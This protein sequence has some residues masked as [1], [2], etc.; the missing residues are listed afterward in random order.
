VAYASDDAEAKK[1]FDAVAAHLTTSGSAVLLKSESNSSG[2]VNLTVTVPRNAKVTV[3]ANKGDVSASG[4]GA[5]ITATVGGDVQL[6]TIA[7]PV[8]AHFPHGRHNFSAHDIQGDVSVDGVMSDLT[9][10]EIRG[11][12][13]QSGDI[14]FGD[15]HME[16]IHGPLHLHT[17]VTDLEV[18][19]L[20]GDMTLDS[21]DLRVNQ[22]KGP[23][24]V[25]THSKDVDL[26]QIYGDSIVETSNGRISVEPAGAYSIEATNKKGDVEVTLPPN[27]SA[28]VSARTHNGDIE[29][30]YPISSTE[31]ENKL[32]TFTI[33]S[34][35][36]RIVL[37]ASNG[38]VHIKKGPGFPSAPTPATPKVPM[39]NVP[40][41][42]LVPNIGT[43]P[44]H[45]K[46]PR[47][48]PA[49][50]VKQ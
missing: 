1:I 19:E 9:L 50:P 36:S 21:G 49:P 11:R 13:T 42:H 31:G 16:S 7:G 24:R 17:S 18:A 41:Y 25:K 8:E 15:V 4:L 39:L 38:D 20:L 47:V 5:G 43:A 40:P 30:D 46:E 14:I 22:A 2:M 26:N 32:A 33:G 35:T 10:S 44:Q 27:A 3:N 28:T 6:N 34:G 12:V 48:P 45:L 23:V 29:S 37:S